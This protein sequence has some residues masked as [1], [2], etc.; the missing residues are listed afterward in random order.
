MSEIKHSL[1]D[2]A[3]P[4][5]ST[6]KEIAIT[7]ALNKDYAVKHNHL[8]LTVNTEA[9]S[10]IIANS[11]SSYPKFLNFAE[12]PKAGTDDHN[13]VRLPTART[14]IYSVLKFITSFE[15]NCTDNE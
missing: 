11:C 7:Y 4:A 3:D 9:Y 1:R 12:I 8:P 6:Q 10:L 2:E 13:H 15:L 5:L 14:T